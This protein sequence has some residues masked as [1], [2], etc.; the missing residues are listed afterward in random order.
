MK[1]FNYLNLHYI[2]LSFIK[3][4]LHDVEK[5]LGGVASETLSKNWQKKEYILNENV[6]LTSFVS[7]SYFERVQ[8]ILW[9]P[10]SIDVDMVAFVT[11]MPDGWPTLLNFYLTHYDREI[12]RIRLSDEIEEYPANQIEYKTRHEK[13]IVQALRDSDKW[14]F[15]EEGTV[16]PFEDVNNYKKRKIADRLNADIIDDYLKQNGIDISNSSF[17]VSNGMAYEYSTILG[18]KRANL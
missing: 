10:K 3:G 16:L 15:Y 2:S 1:I 18:Q 4:K 8:F 11:N 12:F 7:A 9:Q 6:D 14:K 13:R 17:W 5:E